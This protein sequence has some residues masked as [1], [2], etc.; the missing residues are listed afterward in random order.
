MNCFICEKIGIVVPAVHTIADALD[1]PDQYN[2]KQLCQSH[3]NDREYMKHMDP[4]KYIAREVINP[5]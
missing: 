5:V 4:P 1:Y 3:W 2:G